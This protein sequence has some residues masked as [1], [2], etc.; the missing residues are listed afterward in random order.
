MSRSD[1]NDEILC[2]ER[3]SARSAQALHSFV[4]RQIAVLGAICGGRLNRQ[5]GLAED[6][7]V[8]GKGVGEIALCG[9]ELDEEFAYDVATEVVFLAF[10]FNEF[11]S[12]IKS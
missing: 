4:V 7:E 10:D 6:V 11:G 9:S 2:D 5:D 12:P 1:C 3:C 8:G